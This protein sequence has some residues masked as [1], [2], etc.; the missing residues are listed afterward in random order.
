[1]FRGEGCFP[2]PGWLPQ[3]EVPKAE[4]S[5]D[6]RLAV[7]QM[8]FSRSS[9]ADAMFHN[10]EMTPLANDGQGNPLRDQGPALR[11]PSRAGSGGSQVTGAR[12]RDQYPVD[13]GQECP[14]KS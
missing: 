7:Y 8:S 10:D 5:P 4:L 3:G 2:R 13:L 11:S 12:V 6:S 1:M 9:Y 14:F